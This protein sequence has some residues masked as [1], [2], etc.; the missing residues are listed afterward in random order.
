[1][2][3]GRDANLASFQEHTGLKPARGRRRQLI[4]QM[5]QEA[6][7]LIRLLELEISGIREDDECW[8]GNDPVSGTV[9]SLRELVQTLHGATDDMPVEPDANI[10]FL[11]D[12]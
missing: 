7:N 5:Q 6:L 12:E 11:E 2:S 9:Y 10:P 8:A 3:L 4:K 1:M